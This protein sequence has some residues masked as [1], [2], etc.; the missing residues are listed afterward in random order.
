ESGVDEPE[1]GKL[2]LDKL[3]LDKLEFMKMNTASSSGSRTLPVECATKATKDTVHPPNN[4]ST[5]DVQ[6]SVVHESPILNFE[7]VVA[8]IIEA[9]VAPEYSQEVLGFSDVIASENPTPYYDTIVSTTSSTLTL[10]GESDFLLEEVDAFLALEDDHTL[11][12]VDHSYVELKDL[13]LHLEYS[14]LEG[15]DKLPVKIAKDLSV[16]EKTALIMVL[17]SHKRAI[18]WKLSDIKGT[19]WSR[20]INRSGYG[21]IATLHF[22]WKGEDTFYVTGYDEHGSEIGG[23]NDLMTQQRRSRI[24]VTL[25][26]DPGESPILVVACS[27]FHSINTCTKEKLKRC[28]DFT[29]GKRVVLTNM[30]G[31][32]LRVLVFRDDGYEINHENLPSTNIIL[33]P[34]VKK[35]TQKDPKIRHVCNWKGHYVVHEDKEVMLYQTL[36]RHV[37]NEGSLAIPPDFV[38]ANDLFIFEHAKIVYGKKSYRLKLHREFYNDNPSRVN[39]MKLV[40]NWRR[41]LHHCMFGKNKTIHINGNFTSPPGRIYH[42]AKIEWYDLDDSETFSINGYDAMLKDLGIKDGSILFSRFR[43]PGKSLDEG[44]GVVIEDVMKDDEVKEASKTGNS[45]KQLL[46]VT[47]NDV[48]TKTEPLTPPWSFESLSDFNISD[49]PPWSSE[50]MNEKRNKRLSEEF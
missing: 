14:F 11:P 36:S 17:K 30:P 13:P 43:I 38:T 3:V 32:D 21:D 19:N 25:R 5:K 28:F 4:G 46:S 42:C 18:A 37:K 41:I 10:F 22:I 8:P 16:E 27:G 7:P 20:F 35:E 1:L 40:G 49:H 29:N 44:L 50:S 9:V 26:N 47:E 45:G 39:D 12:E 24:L 31:N 15:D 2:E 6:P 23:Y 34:T 48:Q 33:D